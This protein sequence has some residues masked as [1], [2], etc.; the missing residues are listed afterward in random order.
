MRV[1]VMIAMDEE[2]AGEL[3]RE[4]GR[5]PVFLE[6]LVER[7]PRFLVALALLDG[8][9]EHLGHQFCGELH[10]PRGEIHGIVPQIE[11]VRPGVGPE[12]RVFVGRVLQRGFAAA[13]G[14][15][16]ECLGFVPGNLFVAVFEGPV[17]VRANRG[18]VV[19]TL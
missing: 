18:R 8:P 3:R 7:L 6:E 5:P 19:V 13:G 16:V 12:H 15:F 9:V 1:A 4:L 10:L 11:Q 17:V 14:D 2:S